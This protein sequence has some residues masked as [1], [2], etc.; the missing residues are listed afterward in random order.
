MRRHHDTVADA[1]DPGQARC[2]LCGRTVPVDEEDRCALGHRV[3]V[4]P[5]IAQAS[6]VDSA[7]AQAPAP[8]P[9]PAAEDAFHHPY[10]EVLGWDR[11]DAPEPVVPTPGGTADPPAGATFDDL[12]SWDEQPPPAPPPAAPSDAG[13]PGA[14]DPPAPPPAAPSDAGGAG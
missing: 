4:P 8:A 11:V 10:D 7:P 3:A 13:G 2:G 14:A 6:R 12:L 9:V 1:P 5:A